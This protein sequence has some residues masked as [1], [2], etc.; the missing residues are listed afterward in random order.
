MKIERSLILASR[1]PR[2]KEL[3]ESAG[4]SFEIS[5]SDIE[6]KILPGEDPEHY[7]V[8]I[9]EEK[10]RAVAKKYP[11]AYILAA[12]TEVVLPAASTPTKYKRPE[13][14][15]LQGGK[16]FGK[17]ENESDAI[18]MLEELSGKTHIV[19]TG[20]VIYSLRDNYF[21]SQVIKTTVS[22]RILSTKEIAAYVSSGEPMDK[23][24]AY[25]IQ[26]GG[27]SFVSEITGSYTNVVGLPLSQVVE[28]LRSCFEQKARD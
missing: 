13:T 3:L 12:D 11:D 28:Q 4:L 23:A 26:G 14:I 25:A 1:S 18:K 15:S 24:G 27:A 17:P 20:F 22:F 9:A 16:I 8:R 19:L 6:E 21:A 5:V 10:G 2:R 7:V